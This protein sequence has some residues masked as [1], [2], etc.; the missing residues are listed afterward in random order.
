LLIILIGS[1]LIF[2]EPHFF[3]DEGIYINNAKYIYSLGENSIYENIRP[4]LLPLIIGLAIPL[5]L[6]IVIFSKIFLF[7]CFILALVFIYLIS[8]KLKKDSGI[9]STAIFFTS[10]L[11]LF[12]L[13]HILTDFIVLTF[14]LIAFYFYIS[15][16]Y[17]WSGLFCGISVLFRFP[18]G[19]FLIILGLMLI[20]KDIKKTIK[21][22]LYFGLGALIFILPYLI[23]NKMF[24]D[25]FFKPIINAQLIVAQGSLNLF[26]GAFFFIKVLLSQNLILLFIIIFIILLIKK[27]IKI[28]YGYLLLIICAIYFIY[29][30]QLPHYEDRYILLLIP[31][32]AIISGIV[33]SYFINLKKKLKFGFLIITTIYVLLVLFAIIKINN[34]SNNNTD[35]LFLKE[36]GNLEADYL[37]I[38]DPI[39]GIYF[40]KKLHYVVNP[41]Y[42]NIFFKERPE[43]KYMVVSEKLFNCNIQCMDC[44]N[45]DQCVEEEKLN[46]TLNESWEIVKTHKLYGT[47]YYIYHKK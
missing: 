19:I 37:F 34:L 1:L 2:K 29:F 44:N 18:A 3:W 42:I 10:S 8:E 16:K 28:E 32:G 46:K 40:P 17:F 30:S 36:I 7:L 39:A 27:K 33:C 26:S 24:F 43:I 31:F 35:I 25:S 14:M 6:D 45:A 5:G 20:E 15:K 22:G 13:P 23:S 9:F 12:V 38:Y 47:N 41:Y 21:K 11:I 4:P